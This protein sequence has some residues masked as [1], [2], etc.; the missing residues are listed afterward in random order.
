MLQFTNDEQ[1]AKIESIL[2][3]TSIWFSE[4]E[5]SGLN[6]DDWISFDAMAEIVDMLRTTIPQKELFEECWVAYRRKGS[7]KKS[8]DYWKKLTDKEKSMV[9][10]HV[11]AYVSS[12]DVQYQKDFERYLRDKI[13]LTV[14]FQGNQVLYDP[15]KKTDGKTE[16]YMP[17]CGG[18][19]SWN[20]YYKCFVY[21]G[22]FNGN[23]ADGY[24]DNSRPDGATIT[25]NNGRGTIKW[26]GDTK[27]WD[28]I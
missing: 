9:L 1:K 16:A 28:K 20:D 3:K 22:D 27:Q 24:D 15:T 13:F 14:V 10:A 18:A 26:N 19:L 4:D 6:I 21:V 8:L 23:I 2:G 7:K 12:R 11:K 5:N 17:I 25:L